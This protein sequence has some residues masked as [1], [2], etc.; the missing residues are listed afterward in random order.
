MP[1][2]PLTMILFKY[3]LL[4][5]LSFPQLHYCSNML[6]SARIAENASQENILYLSKDQ[7]EKH[8]P[9]WGE[10]GKIKRYF[11]LKCCQS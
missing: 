7:M 9:M 11:Q 2:L 8:L 3:Y 6:N 10:F 5:L 1:S 4:S